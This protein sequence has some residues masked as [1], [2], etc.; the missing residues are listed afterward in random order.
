MELQDHAGV[1][2]AAIHPKTAVTR[3]IGERMDYGLALQVMF[4]REAR[5]SAGVGERWWGP[6]R[7]RGNVR[8]LQPFAR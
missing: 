8:N 3:W 4:Q 1:H 5:K 7:F 2:A 6:G